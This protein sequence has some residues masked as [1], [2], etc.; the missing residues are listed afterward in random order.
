MFTVSMMRMEAHALL[1]RAAVPAMPAVLTLC[2][3]VQ[4]VGHAGGT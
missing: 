4:L 2:R 3:I 1:Y